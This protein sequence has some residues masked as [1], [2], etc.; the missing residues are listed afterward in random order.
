MPSPVKVLHVATLS[1]MPK[2]AGYFGVPFKLSNGLVR[3]GCHVMNFSD[4]EVARTATIIHNRKF[5][6]AG[7]NRKLLEVA[8]AF[9]P[10]MILF[11]HA[12][13]IR[14][15]TLVALREILPDCK[16]VQWNVDPLFEPDNV[17]RINGKIAYLDYTFVSTAGETLRAL[18]QGGKYP[19]S[20]LPNPVDPSIERARNFEHA[21]EALPYDLFFAAGNPGLMRAHA[22]IEAPVSEIVARLHAARPE[23]RL[24]TPGCGSPH[25]FGRGFEVALA[26]SAMGLNLSRR[27]DVPLYSSDRLAQ[28]A[29]SGMLVFVDRATG[30]GGLF[31][32]DCFAFYSTEAE[33]YEKLA[34]FAGDDAARRET[35]RR[36]WEAYRA[37]FDCGVIGAYIVDVV[38][39]RQDAKIMGW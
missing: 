9:V 38:F 7:A 23:L 4:R 24:F 36:G 2:G 11:G 17:D 28:M 16:L 10:D 5:G 32:E 33:L 6:V 8:R 14:P 21:R 25:V 13:T 3:A 26:S 1:M 22:G 18:G 15:A 20:F 39:G 37:A 29:G 30:Y 31:G 35:A 12:D 19:V 34:F 27:N